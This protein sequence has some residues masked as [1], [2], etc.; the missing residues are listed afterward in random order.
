MIQQTDYFTSLCSNEIALTEIRVA[1][2]SD[3]VLP[4]RALFTEGGL[5]TDLGSSRCSNHIG[6][7]TLAFTQD[8]CLVVT[9]Q[10]IRSAQSPNQLTSSG[11]GSA[12]WADRKLAETFEGVIRGAMTRELC[13]ETG[14]PGSA[15]ASVKTDLLGYARA[16]DRGGKPEFFGISHVPL[17]AKDL[18]APRREAAFIA[19]VSSL[20]L[21][22]Q[23]ADEVRESISRF[24]ADRGDAFS[25]SLAMNLWC[26]DECLK[27]RPKEVLATISGQA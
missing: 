12:D 27:H 16:L 8:G 11:S 23:G 24:K 2:Q 18:A 19:D 6:I 21:D 13:E 14:I 5:I 1:G 9:T 25:S 10:A 26:L 4:A 17:R 3:P 22:R 15:A 7:S 20:R